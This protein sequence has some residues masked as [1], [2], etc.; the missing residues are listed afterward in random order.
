[1]EQM[2]RQQQWQQQQGPRARRC[3]C[4]T[5]IKGD[6]Q[7][8][9]RPARERGPC[10]FCTRK[11]HR[12]ETCLVRPRIREEEE[13]GQTELQ[14]AKAR[15]VKALCDEPRGRRTRPR[16][17]KGQESRMDTR[18]QSDEG[19]RAGERREPVAHVDQAA[20]QAAPAAGLLV[21][22]RGGRG[23]FCTGSDS[24]CRLRLREGAGARVFRQPPL[25]QGAR[26]A[27]EKGARDASGH[28]Q[29]C[30]G[31]RERGAGRQPAAGGDQREGQGAH[32]LGRSIHQ[33]VHRELRVHAGVAAAARGA[34]GE[35][36]TWR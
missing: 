29:L 21:G 28:G 25:V 27:R 14:R 4:E 32:V 30:G 1:M 8:A 23:R 31:G 3:A 11:G 18:E 6:R 12:M 5:L 26:R 2:Q 10:A 19:G 17:R 24:A 16:P 35:A 34:H 7:T 13:E 33:L 15:F 22:D 9:V 20:R 36:G